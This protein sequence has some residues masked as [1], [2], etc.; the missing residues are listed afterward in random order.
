MAAPRKYPDELRERATRMAVKA[1]QDPAPR[2]GAR[3]RIGKQLGT[4]PERSFHFDG[5]PPRG[6][7]WSCRGCGG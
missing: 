2:P 4:T 6:T 5:A 7:G 3:A 1:R